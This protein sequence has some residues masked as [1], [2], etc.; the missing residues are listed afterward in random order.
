MFSWNWLVHCGEGVGETPW[1]SPFSSQTWEFPVRSS[2]K[3]P[4]PLLSTP[5]L[6]TVNVK[7]GMGQEA[8]LPNTVLSWTLPRQAPASHVNMEASVLSE[9]L[10]LMNM[11]EKQTLSQALGKKKGGLEGR[12]PQ[13]GLGNPKG[14]I[15]MVLNSK[16]EI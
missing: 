12:L 1:E 5:E 14:L 7:G 9:A 2:A 10:A 11:W 8:S 4:S 15:E 6:S 16:Y 3:V 13:A